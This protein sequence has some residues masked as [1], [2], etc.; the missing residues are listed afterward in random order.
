MLY[1]TISRPPSSFHS[2]R[3]SQVIE[4]SCM[5]QKL[6]GFM[7]GLIDGW[8]CGMKARLLNGCNSTRNT[9][10]LKII[11]CSTIVNSQFIALQVQDER[12]VPVYLYKKGA[13]LCWNSRT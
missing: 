4:C 1:K 8:V 6:N 10:M 9:G 3:I 11:L 5:S 2:V 13:A 7:A 12:K